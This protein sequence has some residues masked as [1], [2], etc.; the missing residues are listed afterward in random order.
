M[1]GKN[2]IL[3]ALLCSIGISTPVLAKT[4]AEK[5]LQ[6]HAAKP[7]GKL[8][9]VPTKPLSRSDLALAYSPGV[10]AVSQAIAKNPERVNELTA[11]QNLIAIVSN[12]TAVLGLGNIGP[13]AAKPVMEGK[14]ILFKHFGG[15][16]CF[17]L[18]IKK[19]DPDE[20]VDFVAALEPTFGG[21]NLEDIKAPE[22]FYI[23][24]KLQER[25]NIP[26]FHDDQHGTAIVVTA[27][28]MNGL[29]LGNKSIKDVRLVA[30]GAGAAAIAS[31]NLLQDMGF[32]PE[33]I[34]VC[35]SR[36]VIYQG[37]IKGMNPYKQKFAKNTELR[38][39]AQA[40]QGADIFLGVSAAGVVSPE[41]VKSMAAAPIILALANP[42]PEIRPEAIKKVR[43]DAIIATGRSDYPNQVNNLLAF[44][45]IFRGALD[46]GATQIN[47]EMK[48][49]CVKALVNITPL[50]HDSII[51]NPFDPR[52]AEELPFAVA[53]AA[54]DSDVA[55]LPLA[56]K[57]S[58]QK[59]VKKLLER[60]RPA[61]MP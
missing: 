40:M 1:K 44:P 35:D 55:I 24:E 3:F 25:M 60:S 34:I 17:D 13:R 58:Y 12:G 32:P 2:T 54:V 6:Y 49:A 38:T 5:A 28:I 19:T 15:V 43:K 29:K 23:E 20:I 42:E 27:A 22:C 59:N 21:I 48:I 30:S 14:A 8:E 36:G 31:L 7:A 4:T 51:P 50:N 10:G 56:D 16:N 45:F 53:Q 18:E 11:R 46:V 9:I 39:L 26:V 61:C 41:M 47:K 52:L 57:A 33:N 37:R